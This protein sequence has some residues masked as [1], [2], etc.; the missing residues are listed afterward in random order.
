MIESAIASASAPNMTS[1]IFS[2]LDKS[3]ASNFRFYLSLDLARKLVRP[4]QGGLIG[5]RRHQH[6]RAGGGG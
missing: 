3:I 2:L 4:R 6:R 5:E 1:F